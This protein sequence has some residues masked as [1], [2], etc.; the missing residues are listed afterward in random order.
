MLTLLRKG[1]Q[2]NYHASAQVH[3]IGAVSVTVTLSRFDRFR[4]FL[5]ALSRNECEKNN[6]AFTW[7]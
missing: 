1:R 6:H 7:L 3:K 2:G 5:Y 4:Q